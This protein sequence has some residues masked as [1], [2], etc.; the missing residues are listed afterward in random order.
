MLVVCYGCNYKLRLSVHSLPLPSLKHSKIVVLYDK[1]NSNKICAINYMPCC[2]NHS[3][4]N[5]LHRKQTSLDI[6]YKKS[7]ITNSV[8]RLK[9]PIK[10]LITARR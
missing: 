9:L 6:N 4:D 7:Y 8:T 3:Y 10:I 1:K 5:I 2:H